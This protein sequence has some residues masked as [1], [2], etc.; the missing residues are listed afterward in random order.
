MSVSEKTID[1]P[2]SDSRWVSSVRVPTTALASRLDHRSIG[3]GAG[4][5]IE[6]VM[7]TSRAKLH[8]AVTLF[9]KLVSGK[10]TLT[11]GFLFAI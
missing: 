6:L 11:V 2:V 3:S 8:D 4:A 1:L 5:L 10:F 7:D 9:R